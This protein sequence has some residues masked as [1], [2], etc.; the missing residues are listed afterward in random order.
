MQNDKH[1]GPWQ[2]PR[3]SAKTLG[4]PPSRTAAGA[5]SEVMPL[6]GKAA[7]RSKARIRYEMDVPRCENCSR[8][9]KPRL[10]LVNSL[11]RF[12]PA[13]CRQFRLLVDP[14]AVCDFWRGKNGESFDA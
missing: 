2:R 14:N 6:V 13:Q 1:A 7:T 9:A 3:P 12:F 5:R 11:P 10:F 4:K 8:Y